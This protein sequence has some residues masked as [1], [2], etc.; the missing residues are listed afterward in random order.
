MA[1]MLEFA[2][3][4]CTYASDLIPR[5]RDIYC[6]DALEL[7]EVHCLFADMIITNPPWSRGVL[8]PLILH[9]AQLRPTWLLFDADWA[10]TKQAKA[11]L[12]YCVAIV[13]VGRVKWIEGSL[14]T[15]KDNCA[16]YLFDERKR[17]HAEF[18]GV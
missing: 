9:F 4:S 1:D 11:Y 14:H 8:H 2:G 16:W 7:T 5:R 13:A 10:Y 12:E 15:G 6:L 17:G 18:Y 3:H